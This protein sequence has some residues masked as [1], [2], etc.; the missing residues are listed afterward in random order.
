VEFVPAYAG[1]EAPPPG[2][3]RPRSSTAS[4]AIGR[5]PPA[6][7]GRLGADSEPPWRQVRWGGVLGDD[8]FAEE[9]R[10]EVRAGGNTRVR[11]IPDPGR[12]AHRRLVEKNRGATWAAMCE[13]RGEW[14][15]NWPG[16][17]RRCAEMTLRELGE[18]AG[19][20]DYATVAKALERFEA[21][22][23]QDPPSP[24]TEALEAFVRS[25]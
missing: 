6:G 24:R 17:R 3:P 18:Q 4:K 1:L 19:G 5:V 12:A 11:P 10:R 25:P 23:K 22:G 7:R 8:A 9:I 16:G 21:R 2:S 15:A 13:K 14:G 20:V